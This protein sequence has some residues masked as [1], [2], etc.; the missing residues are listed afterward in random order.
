MPPITHNASVELNVGGPSRLDDEPLSSELGAAGTSH[1]PVGLE[2]GREGGREGP[3]RNINQQNSSLT[4]SLVSLRP[5]AHSRTHGIDTGSMPDR[6]YRSPAWKPGWC[7]P[8]EDHTHCVR[9]ALIG[10]ARLRWR[11]AWPMWLPGRLA[12]ET[13][14]HPGPLYVAIVRG[15]RTALPSSDF[16]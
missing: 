1:K 7:R 11:T 16:R 12:G 8:H 9:N 13:A 14:K 6:R 15:H 4:Q 3:K 2:G 10:A 5:L